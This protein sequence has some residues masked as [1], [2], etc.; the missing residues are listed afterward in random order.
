MKLRDHPLLTYHGLPSWPPIWT[1]TRAETARTVRG[2]V[3]T[4]QYVYA[5]P[6]LSSKCFLVIDYQGQSYVGT[7]L[8]ES[9]GAARTL[10]RIFT[11]NLK[12]SIKDIGDLDMS[13][14]L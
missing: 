3:G 8:M 1:R 13:E 4:L 9:H 11:S 2:E 10:A 12:R 6:D 7:L 14:T 5:S